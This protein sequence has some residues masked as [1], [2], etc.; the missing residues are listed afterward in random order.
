MGIRDFEAVD[1][2]AGTQGL[3]LIDDVAM[4]P[5]TGRWYGAGGSP[6]CWTV[7]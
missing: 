7:K 6:V 4:R 3:V 2:L 5:T 1:A